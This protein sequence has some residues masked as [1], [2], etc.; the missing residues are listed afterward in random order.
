M[1]TSIGA[2]NQHSSV[3]HLWNFRTPMTLPN[4]A[5]PCFGFGA[6]LLP[7]QGIRVVCRMGGCGRDRFLGFY[8]DEEMR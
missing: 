8:D 5:C 3:F 4:I 2:D 1:P 7:L 6:G